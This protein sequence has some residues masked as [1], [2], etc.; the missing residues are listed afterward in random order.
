MWH[1]PSSLAEEI[2]AP[3]TLHLIDHHSTPPRRSLV[4]TDGSTWIIIGLAI[5]APVAFTALWVWAVFFK[6]RIKAN[7]EAK[8]QGAEK[9]GEL[10]EITPGV[11]ASTMATTSNT[12]S[13]NQ[14]RKRQGQYGRDSL[15][16]SG[17][18]RKH[19]ERASAARPTATGTSATASASAA[20][21]GADTTAA[22][23]RP[24]ATGESATA[25][26]AAPA[27]AAAAATAAVV[28]AE[29]R[30]ATEASATAAAAAAATA[31]AAARAQQQT[32]E[33]DCPHN[34][35]LI[36]AVKRA[37][38]L[39]NDFKREVTEMTTKN[40]PNLV[41]LVGYCLDFTAKQHLTIH[42]RLDI[43]IGMA[44]GLEYLHEFGIVHR[45]IK[46]ANILLDDKMKAKIADFGLVR[47]GEGT[48]VAATRVMGTPGYVDPAYYKSQK[49]TPMADVHS[50]GVVM[51]TVLTA[52][53]AVWN[54]DS[55]MANLKA[56]ESEER[57]RRLNPRRQS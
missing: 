31:A 34:P 42:Q 54:R 4:T 44:R 5:G 37:K 36:W 1:Q 28:A 17:H 52:R 27:A 14:E 15:F 8:K 10:N 46:P 30:T 23:E 29:R 33:G 56:W 55:N 45:D 48:S 32:R 7:Q 51:L 39:T 26:D 21:A 35:S 41:R 6:M 53:K 50:F 43:V 22:T 2:N 57:N 16:G 19:A 38:I 11:K 12:A 47:H 13:R 40:H 9:T 24:T 49:A 25:A 3:A 20:A 18:T